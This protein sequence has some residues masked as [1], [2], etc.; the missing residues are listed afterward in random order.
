ML[1]KL[2][3]FIE[4]ESLFSQDDRLLLAVSGGKDSMVLLH[5]FTQLDYPIGVA[6]YNHELRGPDS[7][8]DALFVQDTC[9]QLQIPFYIR[10]TSQ[11]LQPL[12]ETTNTQDQAR[13]LRYAYLQHIA[14]IHQY[15]YI[16]TAHH[17]TDNIETLLLQLT[18]SAGL[19]GLTAMY[20]KRNNLCRPLLFATRDEI[21]AYYTQNNL[22]HREDSS[23]AKDKYRRNYIRQHILPHFDRLNKNWEKTTSQTIRN[24]QNSHKLLTSY[25]AENQDSYLI[26]KEDRHLLVK[27][28][29]RNI[30]GRE[31]LLYYL[32]SPFGFNSTQVGIIDQQFDSMET[33]GQLHS[34]SHTLLNDRKEMI[35]YPN[36]QS[37]QGA[38][39]VSISGP[40]E[41]TVD[42]HTISVSIPESFS[43]HQDR[44]I[45]YFDLEKIVFPLR[46]RSW[47][48][49]DTFCPLGMNGK[50]KKVKKFLIDQKISRLDKENVKVLVNDDEIIWVIGHRMDDRYKVIDFTN[51]CLKLMVSF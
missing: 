7:V 37:T 31:T 10:S 32:L 33:G 18:R 20:P 34:M 19:D 47:K 11:E 12:P 25:I 14:S 35:I 6:H 13:V 2:R 30:P 5:L 48:S 38:E 23:N 46:V 50:K 16:L 44:H 43:K 45:A 41:F 8:Q 40:G 51:P 26:S 3:K 29:I 42:N 9:E 1:H 39:E 49:G 24:V 21:R 28:A 15:D 4:K 27:D 36:T 17:A 22:N